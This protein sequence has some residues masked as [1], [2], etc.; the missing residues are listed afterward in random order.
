MV[1]IIIVYVGFAW[2]ISSHACWLGRLS[3]GAAWSETML[4]QATCSA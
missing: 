2:E 3:E 4:C 1:I